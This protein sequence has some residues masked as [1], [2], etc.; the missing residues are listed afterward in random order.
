A[1]TFCHVPAD[2]GFANVGGHALEDYPITK[3]RAVPPAGGDEVD[4]KTDLAFAC[5]AATK[6]GMS[7]AQAAESVARGLAAEHPDCHSDLYVSPEILGEVPAPGE[8]KVAHEN[9][10]RLAEC[11]A[12]KDFVI[13]TRKARVHVHF[14]KSAPPKYSAS[15]KKGPRWLPP[16]DA[17]NTAKI[18]DWIRKH[19]PGSAEIQRD[20]YNGR[21]RVIHD[22]M[23][24][25]KSISWTKRGFEQAACEVIHW[26]WLFHTEFSGAASPFGTE[27]L[28]ERWK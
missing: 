1:R 25:W 21:R 24:K 18:T 28:A 10:A 6:P 12:K 8:A 3:G 16:V 20:D 2:T 14:K 23:K 7:D 19:T 9:A 27:A 4:L 15:E 13:S 5:L 26:S 22:G 17:A 11:H